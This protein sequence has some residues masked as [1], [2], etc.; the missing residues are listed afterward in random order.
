MS[1][2]LIT[3]ELSAATAQTGAR[4]PTLVERLLRAL[5][6]GQGVS[7]HSTVA[8]TIALVSL[9]AKLAKSDG[10]AL[11]VESDVFERLH[12]IAPGERDN[13]RRIF[14]MAARDVAGFESCA[15]SIATLLRHD[16]K[17]MRDV[18][19]GLFHI[20]TADG[21]LHPQEERHLKLAA[22][23]FDIGEVEFRAIRALFIEDPDDPYT[24]LG[25]TPSV[26]NA[27]LKARFRELVRKYHPDS[28]MGRGMREDYVAVAS[29]KL[30]TI[31]AA[32]EKIA[33]ERGL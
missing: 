1:W 12:R 8:F 6:F 10:V 14:D 28:L 7:G 15:D 2:E 18:L 31:N 11:R 3:K 19:D 30:A 22:A 33:R 21:I 29:A 16:A 9:S 4:R 27:K 5:G 32:Y 24:V 13:V 25:L 23:A 17:L 26:D 20:A